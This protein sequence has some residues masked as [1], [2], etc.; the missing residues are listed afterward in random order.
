MVHDN[1]APHIFPIAESGLSI[2]VVEE[3][4]DIT[5]TEVERG[6]NYSVIAFE[7]GESP[8]VT[9]SGMVMMKATID[10]A[11]E[12]QFEY[13]FTAPTGRAGPLCRAASGP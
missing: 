3:G 9:A 2:R 5:V 13:F 1:G 11:K 4:Y 6:P 8:T 7:Q 10:I 12:R